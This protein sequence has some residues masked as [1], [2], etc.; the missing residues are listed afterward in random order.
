MLHQEL[1]RPRQRAEIAGA[2]RQPPVG[3]GIANPDHR[4]RH[5]SGA[6]PGGGFRHHGDADLGRHHLADRVE[7]PQARPKP[8]AHA[9]P[10][11][12]PRNMDLQRGGAGQPDEV[13]ATQ[14]RKIDLAAAGKRA[15]PRRHQRQAVLAEQKP[16]DI[17]RQRM[18]GGKAE[19]GGTGHDRRGD[20]GAFAFLDIDIDIGMFAQECRQRLRQM[21]RQARGVGEQ[22]HAGLGAA[23]VSGEIAAHGVDIVDDDAGVIEQAFARRGEFD[24]AAAALQECCAERQ[25]QPLDPRA[26]GRQRQMGAQAPAVMLRASA[27]AM[28]SCRSTRSKRMAVS[29][30]SRHCEPTG[31]ANAPSD[32]RLR[33]A[34]HSSET[35]GLRR[36]R[37]SQ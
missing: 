21:F 15:A 31:R 30:Y 2:D 1:G 23:G 35:K 16:L 17:V 6:A 11:G 22:M 26:G 5:R 9:E 13:V 10:R 25:F 28:N 8:Q 19:I 18:L 29:S 24:A 33:E 36:R 20:I 14:F 4:N 37:S 7:I 32:D 27:I 12:V 3:P 34:I